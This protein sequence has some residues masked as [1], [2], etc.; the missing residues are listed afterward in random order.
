MGPEEDRK[1]RVSVFGLGKLGS[2]VAG[3][4]ASRGFSVIGVDVNPALVDLCKRGIAPVPEPGLDRVFRE[5]AP[6]LTATSEATAAVL[7]SEI[8]MIVVP[9]PS[10]P[11]G[12]YALDYVL[13]AC[14]AIG[15]ALR[16]KSGYHLIVVKSTVLPGSCDREIVPSIERASGK[17]CGS[18]F[19]FCYNPEFIALGN[20]V[21]NLLRP[22]LLLVGESDARAGD[23]LT[24]VHARMLGEDVPPMPRMSCANAELAKIAVNSFVT[25]KITF[26]NLIAQMCEALPGG[27][28]DVVTN[29]IGLDRRIGSRYL[30]GGLGFGGPCFPRDNSA[31]VC[32]ARELGLEFP[33]GEATDHANQQVARRVAEQIRRATPAGDAVAV[34]GLSYKPDTPVV[35]ESQG[36]IIASLLADAG[37]QV[38]VFDPMALESAREVLGDRVIYS[39]SIEDCLEGA[40][41]VA[42]TTAWEHFRSA[43]FHK[44]PE[45]TIVFDCWNLC[46]PEV[47]KHAEVRTIGIGPLARATA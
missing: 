47:R 26:A 19:G 45:G 43:P 44:L 1:P 42:I 11:D 8:S 5:A 14:E 22:D 16:S 17:R 40:S 31:M 39:P 12:G 35:E 30:K 34:L 32:L 6:R 15:S 24:E 38:R 29:A 23:L 28:A 20:V 7:G 10:R 3:C 2:V 36:V 27:N 9:T 33:L 25:M 4:W 18:D 41:T 46:P 21:Q 37:L 13:S